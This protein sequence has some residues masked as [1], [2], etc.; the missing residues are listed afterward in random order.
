MDGKAFLSQSC[1]IATPFKPASRHRP[2]P[3]LR[4][5]SVASC[6]E[7]ET[8]SSFRETQRPIDGSI[9]V[10][11]IHENLSARVG[12]LALSVCL[13]VSSCASPSA[14]YNVRLR[15]VE[16]PA[17]QNGEPQFLPALHIACLWDPYSPGYIS[18]N[19]EVQF[20]SSLASK[21]L[22]SHANGRIVS[23]CIKKHK[24]S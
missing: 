22:V 3:F 20:A 11:K 24:R 15:D 5:V 19:Y 16:N 4:H 12:T 6:A 2:A 7:N 14:A 9:G 8:S 13:G 23:L 10:K 1:V 18:C 21:R 17:M